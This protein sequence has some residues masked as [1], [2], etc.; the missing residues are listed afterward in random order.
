MVT[1]TSD[2]L[3]EHFMHHVSIAKEMQGDVLIAVELYCT[4]CK[5]VI[6]DIGE[7]DGIA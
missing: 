4:Q 2:D 5:E 7:Y 6:I 1:V 3:L